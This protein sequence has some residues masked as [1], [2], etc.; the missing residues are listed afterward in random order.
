VNR[1]RA[2]PVVAA[3]FLGAGSPAGAA[4]PDALRAAFP[5]ADRFDARDVILTDEMASRLEKLARARVRER[6][7]TFYVAHKGEGIVGYAAVHSHVVR[8]KRETFLLA[9]EPDGRIRRITVLSF[10][11]PPEYLPPDRWLEQLRGKGT[12]DRLAV[13]DDL[14]PITGATLTA[15]GLAEQARWLL[16]AL[17]LMREEKEK[18]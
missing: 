9:F 14:P 16:Q 3:M 4:E 5:E 11:E 12:G 1:A 13:G 6:M 15:R 18:R 10:L 17:L 2:L 7:V 8:T